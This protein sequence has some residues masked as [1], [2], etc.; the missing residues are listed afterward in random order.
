MFK[1]IAFQLFTS[2][3]IYSI[4]CLTILPIH[5][6]PSLPLPH[7]Y[8]LIWCL[9]PYSLLM[10]Q[11]ILK[12]TKNILNAIERWITNG[13]H[14]L[15]SEHINPI[16]IWHWK[17]PKINLHTSAWVRTHQIVS[18]FP[19]LLLLLQQPSINFPI[20]CFHWFWLKNSCHFIHQIKWIPLALKLFSN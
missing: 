12:M 15:N 18:Q 9:S 10:K 7:I 4:I 14:C 8:L 20:D 16:Y 6:P 1:C 3:S 19:L 17:G 2:F 11:Y 13:C 5:P